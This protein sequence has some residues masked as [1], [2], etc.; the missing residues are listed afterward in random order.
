MFRTTIKFAQYGKLKCQQE[1][2]NQICD[3]QTPYILSRITILQ[4]NKQDIGSVRDYLKP[5]TAVSTVTLDIITVDGLKNTFVNIR[6][7]LTT[8]T[9]ILVW[10]IYCLLAF[11]R[12]F[13]NQFELTIKA[14]LRI[15]NGPL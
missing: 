13:T 14:L 10:Y 5:C 8:D 15:L 6:V 4:D 7:S 2:F 11:E 12:M 1:N 3:Y 9:F